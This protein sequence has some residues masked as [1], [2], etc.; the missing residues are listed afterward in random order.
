[1]L[2]YFGPRLRSFSV[3]S[4]LAQTNADWCDFYQLI[5]FNK[6]QSLLK[7]V[8][9]R[10]HQGQCFVCSRGANVGQ[11]LA[12]DRVNDQIIAARVNANNLAFVNINRMTEEKTTTSL[13]IK[14]CERRQF[15]P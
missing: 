13:N 7:R 11:L 12:F 6:L 8:L 10:W 15:Y 3:R 1:M 4:L 5:V 2:P 14:Q 9:D